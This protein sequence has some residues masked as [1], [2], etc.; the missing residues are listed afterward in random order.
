M[1]VHSL[2]A[3]AMVLS[4][5]PLGARAQAPSN[6]A[7]PTSAP[8]SEAFSLMAREPEL[9]YSY[10]PLDVEFWEE[11]KSDLNNSNFTSLIDRGQARVKSRGVASEQ[12]A[13]AM[14]AVAIGLKSLGITWGASYHLMKLVRDNLGS[15]V[16]QAAL[17]HLNEIAQSFPTDPEELSESFLNNFEF[18][19]VHHEIQSFISY[20]VALYNQAYGFT[21]WVE[22]ELKRIRPNS[23]WAYKYRYLVALGEVARNRV[24]SGFEKL[25]AIV[26]DPNTPDPIR[27]YSE[28]QL[29]RLIFEKGDLAKAYSIYTGLEGLPI[30]ERGRVVLERAWA[31][32]YLRDYAKALGLI[33]GLEAPFFQPS[34][35]PEQYVLKMLLY[36]TLCHYQSVEKSADQFR[37]NYEKPLRAIR[38]R[39]E[40]HR[41]PTL[42]ARALMSGKLQELANFVNQLREERNKLVDYK[43]D[44]Y[45]FY[46]ELLDLYSKKDAQVRAR[47]QLLLEA[48]TK[49]AAEELLDTEEQVAF[50]DYTAKLD[51]LRIVQRGERR[52]YQS[53]Q[54]SYLTFD[55]I[56]WPVQQ[57]YWLD[58]LENFTVILK[59]RCNQDQSQ[60]TPKKGKKSKET[61]PEEFQ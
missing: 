46:R 55:K 60:P 24:D 37:K 1:L 26:V 49:D 42:V 43:W 32:Y 23:Y 36:K 54:I 57:E 15:Q 19:P 16:A 51:K 61:L 30:R 50:L 27:N 10:E 41:E 35:V 25:R 20:H 29:A 11:I 14:L 3:L 18:G 6:S 47:I 5:A 33:E 12:G 45:P 34:R 48:K 40:L 38:K 22:P 4:L 39:K 31:R 44:D 2:L 59:S 8:S 21:K 17:F 56:F 9:P 53:E 7:E 13:E 28:F 52:E 58:E